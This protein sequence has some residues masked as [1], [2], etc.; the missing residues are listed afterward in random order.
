MRAPP[1]YGYG[2]GAACFRIYMKSEYM[3]NFE[4]IVGVRACGKIP[5]TIKSEK[6]DKGKF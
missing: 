6:P 4:G 5:K 1:G 2:L 3:G